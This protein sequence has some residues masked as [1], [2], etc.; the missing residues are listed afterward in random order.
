MHDLRR[1]A[2]HVEDAGLDSLSFPEHVVFFQSYDS[3]YP[4]A[5]DGN[6]GFGR[7][8]GIF[9]PLFAATVAAGVTTK[10]R[11]G[12]SVLILPQRNPLVLAQEVVA[13]DH[14]SSGRLDLGIGIGWSSEEFA[15][16]GIDWNRRGPRTDDYL[17]AMKALWRDGVVSHHGEFV[18]FNNV[19]A[20]PKPIQSPHPPIWIGGGRG[21]AMSRAAQRGDGWYGWEIAIGEIK[22]TTHELDRQCESVGRDPS[23]VGRKL[24]LAS[25]VRS[26]SENELARY[27]DSAR[28]FGVTEITLAVAGTLDVMLTT[29]DRV[30]AL[31][32]AVR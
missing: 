13:A 31:L 15:A 25:A 5:P 20:E 4:Y 22:A 2:K 26:G 10:L 28:R 24:G 23:E 6:P 11:V 16:L 3:L 27:I 30:A 1:L 8:P 17:D 32:A 19:V 12:T 7:R 18:N 29:V 21:A 9:D 14:A